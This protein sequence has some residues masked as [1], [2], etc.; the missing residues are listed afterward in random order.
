MKLRISRRWGIAILL[1]IVAAGIRSYDLNGQGG[2]FDEHNYLRLAVNTYEAFAHQ[3]LSKERWAMFAEHPP[4]GKYIHA[5]FFAPFT[6]SLSDVQREVL[7]KGGYRPTVVSGENYT[8]GRYS[9]VLL[10]SLTVVFVFFFCARFLSLIVGVIASLILSLLPHFLAYNKVVSLDT[11]T[12]FFFTLGALIFAYA[13]EYNTKKWWVWLGIVSGLALATKFNLA[14]LFVFYCI[15]YIVLWKGPSMLKHKK[16]IWHWGLFS[17]PFL[18]LLILFLS[19]PWLWPSPVERMAQSLHHW[20]GG[21]GV[22]PW[23]GHMESQE[24]K[25][26]YYLVYF[27]FTTPVFILFLW[28]ASIHR[29]IKKR[30]YWSFYVLL[31]F[32][33]PFLW[34]FSP[35]KTDGMRY[36]IMIFPPLAILAA[37]GLVHVCKTK[38]RILYGT[39]VLLV[40][41]LSIDI[42]IHPYYMDYYNI[43][44]GGPKGVQQGN[45]LEFGFFAEGKKEAVEWLNAHATR[46]ASVAAKWNPEHD[47]GGVRQD[48]HAVNLINVPFEGQAQYVMMNHRYKQYDMSK[49]MSRI[50]LKNYVLA[51]SIKAGNGDIGWIYRLA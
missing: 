5:L 34:S 43:L 9:S 16:I 21:P 49:D 35:Q 29:L 44:I 42:W 3:D 6:H 20:D 14:L 28:L 10:G 12:A 26:Q 1:F 17:V 39:I 40:Y 30:G 38:K 45:K 4:I 23:F 24:W 51:Y 50:D 2:T 27:L 25:M 22:E 11:P 31:W 33:T 41:L 15:V 46:G 47:F 18:A 32:L 36:L 8:M 37:Q 13:M 7:I 48:L 19:W